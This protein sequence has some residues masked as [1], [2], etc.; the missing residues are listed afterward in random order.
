MRPQNPP[1]W[2]NTLP[3]DSGAALG[4]LAFYSQCSMI[5]RVTRFIDALPTV[6]KKRRRALLIAVILT[7]SAVLVVLVLALRFDLNAWK[8]EIEARASKATRMQ[9][10]IEGS[11]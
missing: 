6:L 10:T 5:V 11:L 8:P 3:R 2:G 4:L 9:V 7:T 1:R